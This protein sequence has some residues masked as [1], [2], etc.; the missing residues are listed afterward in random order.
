M[1]WS[2]WRP[3]H[4]RA[5]S[6]GLW[7]RHG[8]RVGGGAQRPRA[9]F[10]DQLRLTPAVASALACAVPLRCLCSSR[11]TGRVR[12]AAAAATPGSSPLRADLDALRRAVGH[13]KTDPSSLDSEE[14][15]FLR[16]WVESL[17]SEA[18]GKTTPQSGSGWPPTP[19]PAPRAPP[20]PVPAPSRPSG[21][22]P[23]SVYYPP[24][25]RGPLAGQQLPDGLKV[26]IA[27]PAYGGN[28][29][30]DYMT[31]VVNL[32]TQLKEV[33]WQLQL[34]AGESIIT[35]GRNNA[36]MEF[37]STDCTH[38]LFIDADVAFGVETIKSLLAYDADVALVP[39]PAKN[40]NEQ[41]MQEAALRR[42]G[43]PRLRDGLHY[44]LHAHPAKVQE[45]LDQ[46][47][48]MV[49]VDAGPTGCMLIRR[50]V[51]EVMQEA[52]PDMHCSISGSHAGRAMHYDVWWR[53]FDTM[54]SEDGEFL[55][56]DIAFCRRWRGIGGT[57]WADLGATMS[58]VGRHAFT[59]SM[60]DGA[61]D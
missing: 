29:T 33:A 14:L 43:L 51:F 11:S 49:E 25:L 24:D 10:H 50:G 48:R 16:R 35:V 13:L 28:V 21:T 54:V 37:L 46:G 39:Y 23:V 30:V 19:P 12:S 6:V 26:F 31:S 41:R 59:G 22:A 53:F 36:V 27:T 8:A 61:P 40:L 58:H 32:V 42:G 3:L 18:R 9:T 34:T 5:S 15:A 38:L 2:H 57:I 55:G 4:P 44:V 7:L 1:A 20:A 45:A 47:S 60:L 17:P 52:Y 56:E